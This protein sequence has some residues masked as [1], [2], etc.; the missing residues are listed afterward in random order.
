VGTERPRDRSASRQFD[1][2]G[3]AVE[4][5]PGPPPGRPGLER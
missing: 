1:V 3:T 5:P 4:H 2:E